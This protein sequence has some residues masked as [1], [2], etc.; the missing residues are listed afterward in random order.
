MLPSHNQTFNHSWRYTYTKI[1][2]MH[3][4][5]KDGWSKTFIMI[6]LILIHL[7]WWPSKRQWWCKARHA[8]P[9]IR[10]KGKSEWLIGVGS[11]PQAHNGAYTQWRWDEAAPQLQQ[12]MPGW[13]ESTSNT[14]STLHTT[15]TSRRFMVQTREKERERPCN[16]F[17]L[18]HSCSQLWI[19]YSY[20]FTVYS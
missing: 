9:H 4:K 16:H 13:T 3:F 14:G 17:T 20:K 10:S 18:V 11:G 2:D 7:R 19:P 6:V 12:H 5:A 15:Q 8:R 1:V